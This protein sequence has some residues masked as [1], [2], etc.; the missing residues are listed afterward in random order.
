MIHIRQ[1]TEGVYTI[2]NTSDWNQPLEEHPSV[3]EH[4]E[5]FEVVDADIP[6]THQFLNYV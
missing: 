1:K 4:P 6:E 3:V 5:L 2:V